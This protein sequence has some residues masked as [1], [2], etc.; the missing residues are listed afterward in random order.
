M[1]KEITF[2]E[3]FAI[4]DKLNFRREFLS[5]N[6]FA[7][8]CQ[9]ANHQGLLAKMTTRIITS[10]SQDFWLTQTND[11]AITDKD[12]QKKAVKL[13][14]NEIAQQ[15]DEYKPDEVYRFIIRVPRRSENWV[16]DIS[17]SKVV[18]REKLPNQL[19]MF[20]LTDRYINLDKVMQSLG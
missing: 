14:K 16:F 17:D 12:W 4:T 19:I 3:V 5:E 1:P 15:G 18:E 6:G 2:Q 7:Y 8:Y 13:L 20:K 11:F 10:I 9:L